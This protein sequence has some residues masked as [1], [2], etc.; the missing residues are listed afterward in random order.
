MSKKSKIISISLL[1]LLLI[2]VLVIR[3]CC[4]PNVAFAVGPRWMVLSAAEPDL[5]RCIYERDTLI[6]TSTVTQAVVEAAA[7]KVN[8]AATVTS[9]SILSGGDGKSLV[10]TVFTISGVDP[11]Q[12][13]PFVPGTSPNY[14]FVPTMGWTF[15]PGGDPKAHGVPAATPPMSPTFLG[16]ITVVDT[17]LDLPAAANTS[18]ATVPV[19]DRSAMPAGAPKEVT[20]G[21]DAGHGTFVASLL[22]RMLPKSAVTVLQVPSTV[23]TVTVKNESWKASLS[24]LRSVLSVLA[25]PKVAGSFLNLSMGTYG[26]PTARKDLPPLGKGLSYPADDSWRAP[27]AVLDVLT[28]SQAPQRT[29]AAAGNDMVDQPFYPAAWA[30]CGQTGNAVFGCPTAPT[31]TSTNRIVAVGSDKCAADCI[32]HGPLRLGPDKQTFSNVGNWVTRPGIEGADVIGWRSAD[33]SNAAAGW[34]S[35]AGTSFATPCALA[36][37]VSNK[38]AGTTSCG[39]KN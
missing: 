14:L 26:C 7:T 38:P 37:E 20:D 21:I 23:G 24:D 1:V 10:A 22:Q 5:P 9:T 35:W 27:L 18:G 4:N 12:V 30:A 36:I 28:G 19:L 2:L 29:F 32:A 6:A 13:A 25:N 39:L 15:G 3:A 33:Q 34:Y 11:V 17:G 31:S 16:P 8:P